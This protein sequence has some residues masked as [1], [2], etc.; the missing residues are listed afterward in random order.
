MNVF[1]LNT[2]RCGSSTFIKACHHITNYTSGHETMSSQVLDAR[3]GYSENHI[4][5][6]NR[7]SWFLGR[8]DQ[9][10]GSEAFYVHLSRDKSAT[11]RSF[12]ARAGRGIIKAYQKGILTRTGQ[13]ADVSE[14]CA[15]YVETVTANI[16]CFLKDKPQKM[17]IELESIESGFV[18]FWSKIGAEGDLDKAREELYV[19]HNATSKK[20]IFGKRKG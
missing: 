3:L 15:D 5:A 11:V 17:V 1:I 8:L 6:D 4:E 12:E 14:I 9:K 20:G 2:G 18:D 7:L 16:E 10:F 19:K 13:S